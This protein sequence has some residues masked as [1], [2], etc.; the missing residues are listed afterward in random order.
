MGKEKN[1]GFFYFVCDI[2]A[3]E[4]DGNV[5]I[6]VQWYTGRNNPI[7]LKTNSHRI[8]KKK[9]RLYE[10]NSATGLILSLRLT[11]KIV[12]TWTA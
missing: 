8:W 12:D 1:W 2:M 10:D 3:L 5:N 9:W 11:S 6:L 7:F 4:N